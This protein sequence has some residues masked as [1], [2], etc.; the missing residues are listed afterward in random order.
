MNPLSYYYTIRSY[1][2]AYGTLL[3]QRFLPIVWI[4]ALCLIIWFY[5]HLI[6]YG[7]FYPLASATNRL[8]A[9]GIVLVGGLAYIGISIYR[10]RKRDK[11]LVADL[12]KSAEAEAAASQQAEVSE[13]RDRLKQALALLRRVTKKRFGYVY[14]LPWYVIFGAPGSGKTTALTHSGLKFPLG[15]ALGANSV[16]GIGGTRS[17]NWWFT[18]E[19]ILIDTAGR[20]TTQDDLNGSSKAGWE[21]FLTL[22]KKHRRS[23]PVNGALVTLSIADILTREPTA[24]LEEVRAI[25]Q[26]LSELDEYL[27]A[28]V[29]VYLVLTKS[30]LLTG[31]VEFF[32]GFNAS[33][34]EQVWGTTF[35]LDESYKA[36]DLPER[37]LEEFSLLQ[38]RVDAM[39][40]ERLQQEPD[41]EIR[42][43]IFRFPA[44]LAAL[45][46]RLHE[47]LVEL[48]AGSK[49]VESPLLRGIYFASG[50]QA[51][52]PGAAGAPRMRR[53]Y[54][55]PRLFKEVIFGEAALVARDKRLTHRQL[56]LR[57]IAY[58]ASAVI[59]GVVFSSW[60]ATYFQNSRA[61]AQADERI[62]SYEKLVQ[63][64]P[65]R[66][67]NDTDFLRI[68]PALNDIRGV[69]DGFSGSDTWQVGFGLDQ[70]DKIAG[71]QREAYQRALNSLLLPRL[72]VQLQKQL[73]DTS[74]VRQTFDALKLYGMLGGLGQI[75]AKF[76]SQEAEQIFESLYPGEGRVA[77]RRELLQHVEQLVARR[78]PPIDIDQTLVAKARQAISGQSLAAR[79][80]DIL[81]ENRQV[82]A[83]APWV[84]ADALGPLGERVFQRQSKAALREGIPGLFTG[85]GYRSVVLPEVA[86]AARQA[87]D[88]HWVRGEPP[89]GGMTV[90]SLSLAALQLYFDQ[91]EKRWASLLADL[92][93]KPFQS[94]ADAADTLRVLSSEPG[95][96]ESLARSIANAAD[97]RPKA[98]ASVALAQQGSQ[99][100]A[101]NSSTISVPDPYGR[102]RE[103]LETPKQS[104]TSSSEKP[105]SQI[106]AL[107]PLLGAMYTQLS[108]AAGSTQPVNKI[109]NTDSQLAA[110]VQSLAEES[111]RLPSPID[112]L[113]A[114]LVGDIGALASKTARNEAADKWAGDGARLCS[115][116]MAGR[117]PFDRSARED[118]ALTDF[119]RLFGPKGLFP[120][121]FQNELQAFVDTSASPWRWK[122]APGA[123]GM[124]SEALAQFENADEIRKAFFPND[125]EMPSIR[126]TMTGLSLNDATDMAVLT[127]AG[128]GVR[129]FKS[130]AQAKTFEWPSKDTKAESW[131]Y[132]PPGDFNR[133]IQV[134]GEWATFRLLDKAVI[135]A[136][137]TDLFKARFSQDGRSAE[138]R[139]QFG[140]TLNPYRLKALADFRCPS[141]F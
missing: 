129:L 103:A 101:L 17:C 80:Y 3:G 134:T 15:D 61:L 25:R 74:N 130:N 137:G 33:D 85:E 24:R 71:R 9:I 19:A 95:P 102:L 67:V 35:G 11:A 100:T 30:D 97:L 77:A 5:G 84:P 90:D 36:D 47:V 106:Q 63:G 68:L 72:M 29:P 52:V 131:V 86:E 20:Y 8:I 48:C 4:A 59:L 31:F 56:M 93:I 49:L 23:Q 22:L 122:G 65:V 37:F 112:D 92:N 34:R 110:A 57:R 40:I 128:E 136:E 83:L 44:E 58:G 115:T 6:G 89:S 64:I 94:L 132:M 140:G 114:G 133:K 98:S 109:F 70:S 113:V 10:A 126:I 96:I 105:R 38:Q 16:Q 108:R 118:M 41:S 39:L 107:K 75:D 50:T 13:I 117:Y 125:G 1:V 81:E 119:A 123:E 141:Q 2:E 32:D 76:A 69:T 120:S 104:E 62:S 18:D 26:R 66:D 27:Q 82:R 53:S 43:R 7:E 42:G 124:A 54:F 28:R 111:R 45:K 14:E 60:I 87:L 139:V 12:E 55:L 79:A 51:E 21:G 88:E 78:L 46:E 138:F 73:G 127:T 121:F 91:Y 99:S 116:I 135:T